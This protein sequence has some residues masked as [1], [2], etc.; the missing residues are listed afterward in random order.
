MIFRPDILRIR[1]NAEANAAIRLVA[2]SVLVGTAGALAA[3][4]FLLLLS[5]AE[6]F[7][8]ERM[9]GY[10]APR[11]GHPSEVVGA[12]SRL[13][14]PGLVACG[15]L[16]TA[17]LV[18]LSPEVAGGGENAV[19]HAFH[20]L[21]GSVRRRVAVFKALASAATIGTGGAAGRE[22]PMAQISA[23]VACTIS[24]IFKLSVSERRILV[25]AGTAAGISAMFKSPLGA[26]FLAVEILYSRLDI[27][28]DALLYAIIASAVGFAV[29]GLFG[30]WG[31][32]FA[33]PSDLAFRR[34]QE[35][36]W[37]ALLGLIA[38]LVSVIIPVL[39]YRIE[40]W[41]AS[42]SIRSELKPAVGGMLLGLLAAAFP[43]VLGSGYGWIQQAIDGQLS[44]LM[45]LLLCCAKLIAFPLTIGSGGSGGVFAPVLFSGAMFGS[46]M[47]LILQSILATPPDVGTM[48]VVGMAAFFAGV[49][50]APIATLV[51][52]TELT[53]GHSIIVPTMLAVALAFSLEPLVAAF[54]PK[55]RLSLY[56]AQV[57]SRM[58]SP[59]HQQEYLQLALE[60]V[61][62]GGV[63]VSGPLKLPQLGSLLSLG[64]PIPIGEGG[65]YVYSATVP[66]DSSAIGKAIR[67]LPFVDTVLIASLYRNQ[68]IVHP[69]GT[70]ELVEGDT[71]IMIS[72]PE[73]LD[74]LEG[75]LVVQR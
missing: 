9:A 75:A 52:A 69:R 71:L 41:F 40:R 34:P 65:D 48:T 19:I 29:I 13:V 74:A 73:H 35:L 4:L 45:L 15:G 37:Y 3:Q 68:E 72:R 5:S 6:H 67:D 58:D 21:G 1:L 23:S 43:P 10:I 38:G 51:L 50:R 27:E 60:L 20:Q 53:G 42:L 64:Q 26:A 28:V 31:A 17:L 61:E 70:T 66:A 12:N 33:I 30:G 8:L 11:K 25:V 55:V 57:P 24:R 63:N 16:L 62:R 39:Y 44:I 14:I 49:G 22:G 32:E 7:F 2:L 54:F 56:G 47:A 46:A 18:R 36:V 59:T